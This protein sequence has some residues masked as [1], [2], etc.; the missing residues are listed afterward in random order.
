LSEKT[1]ILP[2]DALSVMR[3]CS[4]MR[5][6][7][8]EEIFA[9]RWSDNPMDLAEDTLAVR[10]PKW[11]AH[12]DKYGPVAVYGAAPMWPGVW[13]LWLY[14]TPDFDRCGGSL[15]R[16]LRRVMMPALAIAGAHRAEARSLSTHTEAHSWLERLGGRREA[17]LHGY[18]K[19]GEDF[20][21]FAWKVESED[22]LLRRGRLKQRGE[23]G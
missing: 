6:A 10:G 11:V 23:T 21:V 16:H 12:V 14:G 4:N 18:G 5:P 8:R 17:T 1:H 3:V 15:S 22:V 20:E 2:V 13:S 9:L 7:D 19:N